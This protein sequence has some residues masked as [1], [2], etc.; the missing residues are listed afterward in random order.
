LENKI[1][2]DELIAKYL[3]GEANPD[4]ALYL[5]DWKAESEQNACY[6][7]EAA[8]LFIS[9]EKLASVDVHA[10][11]QNV[12]SSIQTF[13]N[14]AKPKRQNYYWGMAAAIAILVGVLGIYRFYISPSSSGQLYV[15]DNVIKSVN[16]KDESQIEIDQNSSVKIDADFNNLNRKVKLKGSAYFRVKHDDKIPFIVEVGTL[17]IKDIGTQF[18]IATSQNEDTIKVQVDEGE[19][20]LSDD[21]GIEKHIKAN[22]KAIYVVSQKTILNAEQKEAPLLH[23]FNF[24]NTTLKDAVS[25]ISAAYQVK[26][27]FKNERIASCKITAQFNQESIDNVL[28]VLTET[29]DLEFERIGNSYLI[30]GSQCNR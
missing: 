23:S 8:A 2:I 22:A 4:E 25:E 5:E 13:D 9:N 19:V 6:F 16:L 18:K 12:H 10:A 7:A 29:L 11:W 30:L 27:G 28:L 24:K 26:I 14:Q 15:A 21:F 20:V 3:S 1:D 17:Q